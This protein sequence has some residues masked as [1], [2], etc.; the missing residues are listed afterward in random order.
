[1]ELNTILEGSDVSLAINQMTGRELL[2]L[3]AKL[4]GMRQLPP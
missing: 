2:L 3:E 1:M 4:I